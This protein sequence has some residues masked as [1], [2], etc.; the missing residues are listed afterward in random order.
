MEVGKAGTGVLEVKMRQGEVLS[1]EAW[2]SSLRKEGIG[3]EVDPPKADES[4]GS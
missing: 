2:Q 3:W 4:L 1:K